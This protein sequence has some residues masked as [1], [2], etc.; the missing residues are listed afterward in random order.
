[1]RDLLY[2]VVSVGEREEESYSSL[3]GE[4]GRALLSISLFDCIDNI[5][6]HCI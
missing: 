6:N 1:M 3:R 5:I 4:D 2:S